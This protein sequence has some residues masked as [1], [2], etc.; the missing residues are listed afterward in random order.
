MFDQYQESVCSTFKPH[1]GLDAKGARLANWGLGLAGESGEVNELLKHHLYGGAP[2]DQMELAKELGDVLWYITA[3]AE[4]CNMHLGDIAS[5]NA[6]KLQHRYSSGEYSDAEN[7]ER[8]ESEV[9]FSTTP[10]YQTIRARI[11]Q[12]PAPLN[13]IFVGP[14][15]S[16]KTTIAKIIAERLGFKYHKCDYRQDNK[17]EL[18]E[19][20]L[21]SQINVVYDRFYWPD[22][23]IYCDAKDIER[24]P[25]Y[26]KQYE[27]IV[28][29][30]R[31]L[32][33]VFVYVDADIKALQVRSKVWQDDY[34]QL[35][36]LPKI[37]TIY[38]NWLK[39]LQKIH[40]PTVQMD[41]TGIAVGSN[42]F[43]KIIDACIGDLERARKLYAGMS[44]EVNTDEK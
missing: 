17:P 12:E 14:D 40:V 6:A 27:K 9:K 2:L 5:L 1:T 13:V 42:D 33:P 8:H 35:G 26:W 20:L 22:D 4:T 39:Y 16:G 25:E 7:Q 15:G 38:S 31:D 24:P 10:I 32:N 28:A 29:M 37:K 18:A 23:V 34:I 36:H 11:L 21:T 3:I 41:T 44:V 19:K 30:L 43:N